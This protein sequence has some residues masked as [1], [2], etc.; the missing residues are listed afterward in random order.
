MKKYFLIFFIPMIALAQAPYPASN[1]LVYGSS[2]NAYDLNNMIPSTGTAST[3]MFPKIAYRFKAEHTGSLTGIRVYVMSADV[4]YGAGNYGT[5]FVTLRNDST[6]SHTPAQLYIASMTHSMH[7]YAGGDLSKVF[8][9]LTF[10]S[11]VSVDSGVVYHVVFENIEANQVD[12]YSSLNTFLMYPPLSPQQ[13]FAADVDWSSLVS[14]TLPYTTWSVAATNTP[15]MSY[16]YADGY[17]GGMGYFQTARES[18]HY[19]SG[20]AKVREIFTVT[21]K[22]RVISD[23]NFW[24]KRESGTD[25]LTM[26]LEQGDG[27]LIEQGTIPAA[28]IP[29]TT[30]T[31]QANCSWVNFTF[32]SSHTLAVGQ[33]YHIVLSTASGSNYSAY[34]ISD[35]TSV[36]GSK[37]CFSDG[38]SQVTSDG[39]TWTDNDPDYKS[40]WQFYFNVASSA[41]VA[42][43]IAINAG[44]SQSATVST[45]VSIN[46]SVIVRDTY[47]NP[48]SGVSVTF[49][50]ATGGGSGT[51]LS[52]TTNGSGI[53]TVGSWT[54]GASVGSNTMTATSTGLTG[55]PVTFTATGTAVPVITSSPAST[56]TK[57]ILRHR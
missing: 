31:V 55:S 40:D 34:S 20:N 28:S 3:S 56:G 25:A 16:Y 32:S 49:A 26:R 33:T 48:V 52:A 6:A 19:I 44:N 17:Y 11:P 7:D 15:I 43:Q 5:W 2:V 18:L 29:T 8:P 38:Y 53:A 21:T 45:S 10:D 27:T 50:V 4:G 36:F 35:G 47:D 12:N 57:Y 1:P 9:M 46:P 37:A 23:I 54:L 41:P 24:I 13:P 30:Y 22:N 39:T 14:S 42:T 51:S